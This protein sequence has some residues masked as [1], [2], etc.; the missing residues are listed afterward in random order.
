ME[1]IFI[2]TENRKTNLPHKFVVNLPQILHLG[3][4]DKHV[5]L[6]NVSIY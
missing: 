1:K 6:Q 2:N 4:L 3:S 5:A